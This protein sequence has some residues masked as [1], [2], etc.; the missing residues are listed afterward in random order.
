MPTMRL[1]RPCSKPG[2]PELVP[3]GE[4]YCEKHRGE[5][6]RY[7]RER[8]SAAE[9][10]YDAHWRK[11]RAWKLSVSPI[12]QDCLEKGKV[13]PAK[14][15]HHN[16]G[17]PRNNTPENLKSLCHSCH[18]RRTAKEQGFARGK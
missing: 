13:T 8:G 2:C 4:R 9:R 18:S 14:E 16:D 7:D 15:V 5:E 1:L 3:R 6:R 11:V 12:C 10:G 17:N